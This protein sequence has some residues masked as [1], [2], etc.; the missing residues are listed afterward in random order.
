M[1]KILLI[2]VLFAVTAAI[3]AQEAK[4]K[5][6]E[7]TKI[8]SVQE[9]N[10]VNGT[11]QPVMKNGK[12]YSQWV[13]EQEALNKHKEVKR[14]ITKPMSDIVATNT[15]GIHPAPAKPQ[16]AIPNNG[17]ETIVTPEPVK[18]D[19]VEAKV[20]PAVQPAA[21]RPASDALLNHFGNGQVIEAPQPA[22][23]EPGSFKSAVAN[24]QVVA[25]AKAVTPTRSAAEIENAKQQ[26]QTAK[27]KV[28]KDKE[29]TAAASTAPEL[30]VEITTDAPAS[31]AP[32]AKPP[33]APPAGKQE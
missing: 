25:P 11:A 23:A 22:A 1:K 16:P 28:A 27:A 4:S 10:Q 6:I 19:V 18:S 21:A 7:P 24:G 2:C 20:N 33:V 26:Q 9:T 3:Y 5:S 30:K 32:A 31:V 14:V 15:G 13:A 12:P 17:S 29:V 8:M